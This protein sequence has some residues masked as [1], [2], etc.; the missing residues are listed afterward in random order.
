MRSQSVPFKLTFS[1]EWHDNVLFPWIHYVPINK[2]AAE[3][4]ELIPFFKHDPPGEEIARSIG[5]GGQEWAQK[6]L[7][8]EDMDV[9]LFRLLLEYVAS[10]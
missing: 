2:D 1:R 7:R 3:I 8:N 5:V 4:P 6:T 10:I 9:Y